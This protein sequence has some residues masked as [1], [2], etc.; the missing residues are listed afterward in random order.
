M[1]QQPHRH[2]YTGLRIFVGLLVLTGVFFVGVYIGFENRPSMQKVTGLVGKEAPL[3]A[4][5]DF[6][7]F[8]KAWQTVSEKLPGASEVNNQDRVYGAIK[9]MLAAFGD[10]YTTFFDP[11]ESKQFEEE[12]A[13]EFGGVGIEL[14]QKEGVLTVIAPLKNSPAYKVGIQAGDKI[15]KIDDM[16]SAD[17]GIDAAITRIRGTPGTD[18]AL[19]I[20]REGLAEPKVYKIT[21]ETISIP[22]VDTE[23]FEAEGVFVIKLYNF[24]AQ[25][26]ELFRKALIEF[27]ESGY[28]KLVL[29]LRNNPGGYLE[30][31]VSMASWFLPEGKVVV[32]EIGKTE[33]EVTY[34]KSRGPGIFSGKI[35][36][37]VLVNGGSASASEILAGAL[38]EHGVATLAGQKTFGKGSVQELVKLTPDTSLKVTVA[39]WYTP[40][41]VSISDEGLRPTKDIAASK[42]RDNDTQLKE[43][44][45]L[46]Q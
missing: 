41:G 37:V 46:L 10:P 25:S 24:S 43:A 14:G 36:M 18:V 26:P 32:K 39:K 16:M 8:W 40:K 45:K 27:S 3:T 15:V 7:P 2:I 28:T 20:V 19:T 12:I 4:D 6:G 42:D 29:D 22:T 30:A 9:G 44:V 31:A 34:H 21:R 38:S 17:I 1:E 33:K 23:R 35:Q 11:E 5:A 13:G